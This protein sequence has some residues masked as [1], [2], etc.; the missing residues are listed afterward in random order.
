[1]ERSPLFGMGW[2]VPALESRFV[3]LD[4]RRWAFYQP[5]GFVRIFVIPKRGDGKT[6]YGG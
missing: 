6:L 1:M 4:E 3:P 5:D 2:S